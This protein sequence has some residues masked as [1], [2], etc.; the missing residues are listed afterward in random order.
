MHCSCKGYSVSC[1]VSLF[2][3]H[4]HSVCLFLL[5]AVSPFTVPSQIMHRH[6]P[7]DTVHT[8]TDIPVLSNKAAVAV[9]VVFFRGQAQSPLSGI[10]LRTEERASPACRLFA[11]DH[12]LRCPVSEL[13][14]F[15][16]FCFH[17]LQSCLKECSGNC[18]HFVQCSDGVVDTR[19]TFTGVNV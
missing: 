16:S 17:M 18:V 19:R 5:L 15:S 6:T 8:H 2:S 7:C 14:F 1:P 3:L 11:S 10:S 12:K 9:V 4:P 13:P